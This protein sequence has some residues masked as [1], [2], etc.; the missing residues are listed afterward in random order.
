M[1][2]GYERIVPGASTAVLFLHGIVGTPDHFRV[3]VPLVP[4]SVSVCNLLLLGHGGSVK[5][6]SKASM[7][8]WNRQVDETVNRLLET[9]EHLVIAAHSMGTLFAIRQAIVRKDRIKALYLLASPLR[10]RMKW[11]SVTNSLKTCMGLQKN[12][13]VSLAAKEAYGIAA[14]WRLWRY[15]GWIPRYL[16]LLRESKKTR[17]YLPDLT[18]P[19]H[20]FQS[21]NDEVVSVRSCDLFAENP[22]ITCSILEHSSHYYYHPQDLAFLKQQFLSLW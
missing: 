10:I 22:N 21:R 11:N 3:F 9:H 1:R 19:C 18:T 20:V 14:D 2:N 16:E 15:L 7:A 8:A 6:F 13:P 12:D 5:D 17:D 4:D